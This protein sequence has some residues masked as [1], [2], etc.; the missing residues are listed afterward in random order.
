MARID[1]YL[2]RHGQTQWNSEG[3]L[4]GQ[5]DSPLSPTGELQARAI[6]RRLGKLGVSRTIASDLGRTRQTARHVTES[7]ELG[8][9]MLDADWRDPGVEVRHTFTHFHLTLDVLVA[10]ARADAVPD[11]GEFR[12][13]DPEVLP[14]VMKKVW[15]AAR[16]AL[17]PD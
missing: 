17:L 4:Q 7:L 6:A 13:L 16:S 15:R 5:Q 2:I 12:A 9:T 1:L 8:D 11:T 10:E 14:T 3:R